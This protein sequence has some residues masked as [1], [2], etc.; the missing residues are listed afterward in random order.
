MKK[1][2]KKVIIKPTLDKAEKELN[3]WRHFAI[4]GVTEDAEKLQFNTAIARLME[5]TNALS[6]YVNEENKNS[7]FL[8]EVL[9]DYLKLLAPFAPHFAE[10]KWETLGMG[11]SIFNQTWPEFD[12]SALIKD[13]VEIAIQVNG[14][15]KSRINVASDLDEEGIKEASLKDETVM[16]SLEGKTVRKVIV[17]KG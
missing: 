9:I 6:K 12:A 16:A 10:E 2:Q 1:F 17:I 11:Y 14:K 7:N 3:Y 4:K 8:K 13:E 5:L 15:I